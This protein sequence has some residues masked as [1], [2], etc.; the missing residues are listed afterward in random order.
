MSMIVGK[1]KNYK[2][3]S[4]KHLLHWRSQSDVKGNKEATWLPHCFHT[5][6]TSNYSMK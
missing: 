2:I 1:N 3:Y 4:V 5:Y 6:P